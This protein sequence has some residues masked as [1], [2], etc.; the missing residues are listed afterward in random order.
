MDSSS[1]VTQLGSLTEN[2]RQLP[3]DYEFLFSHAKEVSKINLA[4]FFFIMKCKSSSLIL[5]FRLLL[6]VYQ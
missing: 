4:F 5:C 3:A 1:K 6:N 2:S